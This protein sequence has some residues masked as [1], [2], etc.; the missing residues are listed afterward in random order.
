MSDD[1]R[2]SVLILD[3]E[4]Q[5]A[6]P[7]DERYNL[8]CSPVGRIPELIIPTPEVARSVG[9]HVRLGGKPDTLQ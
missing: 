9:V 7:P 4:Y 5:V 8:G 2:V 6:C 1:S 3:K